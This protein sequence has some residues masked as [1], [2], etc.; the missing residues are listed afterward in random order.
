MLL[1]SILIGC[2]YDEGIGEVDFFG[3]IKIPAAASKFIYGLGDEAVE[4]DDLRGMGPVY[5]GVF[6][7]VQDDLYSYPHPEMGPILAEGQDG[8]TYPYGGNS[9]GRF[10]WGCYEQLVCKMVTGRFESYADIIDFHANVLNDPIKTIDGQSITSE[11][12]YRERCFEI[13]FSTSDDEMLFIGERDFTLEGDYLV[14]DIEIPQVV[15]KEGMQVWAW[16]DMPSPSFEFNTCAAGVGQTQSYY[17]EYYQVGTNAIDVINFPGKY[18]DE[19]DWISQTPAT[20]TSVNDEFELEIG[21]H[22][23]EE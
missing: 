1:L 21:Y 11:A 18:I 16:V 15:F 6:P 3:T 13:T 17:N 8:N 10:D 9:L 2:A 7:S 20:I 5:I 23:V 19:G 14:S 12:E 4:I 22:Y